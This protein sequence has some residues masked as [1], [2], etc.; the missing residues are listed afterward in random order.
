M[1]EPDAVRVVIVD[2]DDLMRAGLRGV[3]SSD[4][5]IDVVGEASDGR[6]AA[7]RTRL[8]APDVILM[9]VRMSDRDPHD[10]LRGLAAV[11]VGDQPRRAAHGSPAGAGCGT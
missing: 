11:A 5:R 1:S 8:L 9:D 7:Y 3:L 10:R 2:D 6:D 4:E